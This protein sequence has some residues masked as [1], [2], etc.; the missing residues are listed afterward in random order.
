[1]GGLAQGVLSNFD[2]LSSPYSPRL[3]PPLAMIFCLCTNR[4][5]TQVYFICFVLLSVQGC[6]RGYTRVYGVYLSPSFLEVLIPT[7][8]GSIHY[9]YKMRMRIPASQQSP[10]T[11]YTHLFFQQYITGCNTYVK[12]LVYRLNYTFI[13]CIHSADN[14]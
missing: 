9:P 7:Y 4:D 6:C 1:M 11:T 12:S 3:E 2:G 8:S 13:L 5:F 14:Q 10:Y